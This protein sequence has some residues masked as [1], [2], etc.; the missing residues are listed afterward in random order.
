M[1]KIL[2]IGYEDFKEII[3]KDLYYIDKTE[4]INDLL[5]NKNK[6]ALFPRPR[7]FG[8]SLF[9]SMLENFFNIEKKEINKH[10]FEGLNISK[11]NY[12]NQLSSRPVI[13]LDFKILK[14][15]DFDDMYESFQKLMSDIYNDKS[16]L[17]EKLNDSEKIQYQ[18]I[19]HRQFLKIKV[20]I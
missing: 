2:P 20:T 17:L 8:K 5:N 18:Q 11:S 19:C 7:R 6:V 1:K 3:E 16:Y 13:K 15:D 9:I 12:Y 14:Q 10:L 4:V